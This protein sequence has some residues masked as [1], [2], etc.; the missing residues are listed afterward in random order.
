MMRILHGKKMIYT[1]VIPLWVKVS[2]QIL[3]AQDVE[4]KN[5]VRDAVVRVFGAVH[6]VYVDCIQ[7]YAPFLRL[8]CEPLLLWGHSKYPFLL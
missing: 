2:E 3:L 5:N 1:N 6:R 7:P 8:P 4:M